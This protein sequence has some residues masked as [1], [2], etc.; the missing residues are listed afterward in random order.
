MSESESRVRV[1]IRVRARINSRVKVKVKVRARVKVR[2][3]ARVQLGLVLGSWLGL[4]LWSGSGFLKWPLVN[5]LDFLAFMNCVEGLYLAWLP[6][7]NECSISTG[8]LY[9][10]Y[11][12]LQFLMNEFSLR[13]FSCCHGMAQVK[14]CTFFYFLYN[15]TVINLF[16]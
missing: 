6:L 7:R 15:I 2:I 16:S 10:S 1:N 12:I 4:R 8:M 5:T 14:I 3:R 13:F 9:V 11:C